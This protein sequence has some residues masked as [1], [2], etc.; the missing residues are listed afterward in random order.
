M[1][2]FPFHFIH[3]NLLI[4]FFDVQMVLDLSRGFPLAVSFRYNSACFKH[5][6]ISLVAEVIHSAVEG[7]RQVDLCEFKASLVYIGRP[8]L[9]QGREWNGMNE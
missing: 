9:K 1:Y 7:D 8:C 2:L 6:N 3:F 4:S 5:F